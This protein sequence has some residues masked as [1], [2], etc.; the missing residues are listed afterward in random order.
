[1][2]FRHLFDLDE[3]R[4]FF[5]ALVISQE[6]VFFEQLES[7]VIFGSLYDDF[8]IE[9]VLTSSTHTFP[10]QLFLWRVVLTTLLQHFELALIVLVERGQ[11][12]LI[13]LD[14][15]LFIFGVFHV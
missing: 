7:Y 4:W 13:L 12:C 15:R 5:H 6:A 9:G 2:G 11:V 1:M 3:R 10:D 14:L 8:H